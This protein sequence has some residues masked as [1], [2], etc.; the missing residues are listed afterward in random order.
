MTA[1]DAS[2]LILMGPCLS[3]VVVGLFN[4][5]N[6]VGIGMLRHMSHS[7]APSLHCEQLEFL[8]SKLIS[9]DPE[10]VT[11]QFTQHTHITSI[12]LSITTDF[13]V[14]VQPCIDKPR[15]IDT[16]SDA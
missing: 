13:A 1:D 11:S 9:H 16:I 5:H 15:S 14:T 10:R 4:R 2:K 7:R 8:G 6:A 12:K 3:Y